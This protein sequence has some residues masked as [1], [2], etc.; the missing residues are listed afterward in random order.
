MATIFL[1]PASSVPRVIKLFILAR[2]GGRAITAVKHSRQFHIDSEYSRAV[3]LLRSVQPLDRL[4]NQFEIFWIFQL[5]CS[6]GVNFAAALASC[7]KSSFSI[8]SAPRLIPSAIAR[9]HVP[10]LRGG[11]NKHAARG[12]ASLT[13]CWQP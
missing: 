13:D 9:G 6:G 4:A 12:S 7:H 11:G 8:R 1:T 10:L 3:Q 2:N 5:T